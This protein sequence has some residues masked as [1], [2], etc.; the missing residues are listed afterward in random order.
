MSDRHTLTGHFAPHVMLQHADDINRRIV[1]SCVD[2][3]KILNL[4][5]QIDY[6]NSAG[7]QHME[8]KG[9]IEMLGRPWLDFWEPEYRESARAAL[10]SARSGSRGAF[11]GLSRTSTGRPKW[12]DVAVTP[13]LGGDGSVLQLLAVARDL[14]ERQ[15]EET[16]RAGQHRVLEMIAAGAALRDVLTSLVYLLERHCDGMQCS[17]LFLDE[18]GKRLRRGVAP[19]LPEAFS[20][21]LDGLEIGPRAGSCGTAMYLG[22]PVIVSDIEQDALWEDFRDM[23]RQFGFRACWS[24]PIVS[25]E[26]KVLGTF[27]IYADQPSTPTREDLRIMDI[28]ASI[29]GIAIERQRAH[30]ALHESEQR[31]RAILRAIPD[32]IFVTSVDGVFLD[33]HAKDPEKLMV[34]PTLFLGRS[35]RDIMPPDLAET[36]SA[37]F[38][39]VAQSDEPEKVEYSLGT[40][41]AERFY[42][43]TVVR[44]DQDKVLSIVRDITDRRRT[45][46]DAAAQRQELVHLNRVAMLGELTGA[47]AHELS[48]P[49]AAILCSAQAAR[50]FIDRAPIEVDE[51]S[52]AV[53]DIIRNDKRAC[54][55]IERLRTL[56]KK[57]TTVR[58]RLDLPEITRDALDLVRS[59]LL[60]RRISVT[61]RFAPSMPP[62]V[63]DRV[64]LQQV[65]L[66]LVHNACEAMAG[67]ESGERKLTIETAAD[68]D[69]VEFSIADNGAGIPPSQLHAVFEP[70][71]TFRE[72]GLGLGLAISRSI[73]VSHGG[74]ITSENNADQGATF[75][76][77]L[78]AAR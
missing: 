43:A 22:K 4:D 36:L 68:G 72:H 17:V 2:C 40:D 60:V 18:G 11:Q 14:T 74:R 1:D 56:L 47:L 21:A 55:V 29:A 46:L 69:H 66:N 54:A 27:A 6:V 75:R 15:K 73:I 39:R 31:N 34:Q 41:D 37:A 76:C 50:R 44:C 35:V 65:I 57:G 16:F 7:V 62:V 38:A 61:T 12:W 23:A 42:E 13:I 59:D 70:F 30:Q 63:G 20:A 32:W 71:V 52:G 26:R 28:A 48:Q 10:E 5:G 33:Y 58:Q 9:A 67:I 3:L 78:P 8:L 24:T 77:Q 49:L 64:Q 51:V 53:D 45:E 19:S 25:S